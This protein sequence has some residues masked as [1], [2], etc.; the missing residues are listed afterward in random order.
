MLDPIFNMFKTKFSVLDR[1]QLLDQS[2]DEVHI[3]INLENVFKILMTLRNNNYFIATV[4][5]ENKFKLQLI[6][7]IINLAQ[8]YRLYCT[9]YRKESRIILYWNYPKDDYNNSKYISGYREYYNH[10]MFKNEHC[11]YIV[12]IIRESYEFMTK[13]SKFINQ[14]YIVNGGKIDSS[15]VPYMMEHDVYDDMGMNIQRIIISNAKYDFQ[16]AALGYTVLETDKDDSCIITKDNLINILKDKMNIK[17][18]LTIPVNLIPFTISL[19]GDKYRNIPKLAGIGLGTIL[20]MVNVALEDVLITENTM[21]VDMLS[22]IISNTHREQFIANYLCTNLKYQFEDMSIMDRELISKQV[23]D[24][25]DD[26]SLAYINDKYFKHCP[27]MTINTKSDQIMRNINH[28][29]M[30]SKRN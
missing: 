8:H 26:N 28:S 20:K 15:V 9:K 10:K 12:R 16:Y 21:E 14:V 6:S 13:L 27:I 1:L 25:F 5:D 7:N 19:L 29:D 2:A 30:W 3:Y 24:K 23:E 17:N 22:K 11:E 4:E 18:D